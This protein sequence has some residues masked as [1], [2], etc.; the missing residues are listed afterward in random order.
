[1]KYLTFGRITR[2]VMFK[3]DCKESKVEAGRL[4]RRLWYLITVERR[5]IQNHT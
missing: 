1:M 2:A 4:G 3:V 5:A